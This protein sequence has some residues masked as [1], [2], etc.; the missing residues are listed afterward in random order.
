MCYYDRF[1]H[2]FLL[3]VASIAFF[4]QYLCHSLKCVSDRILLPVMQS[5]SNK[6][7]DHQL[8]ACGSIVRCVH[9]EI[10]GIVT[11]LFNYRCS[12]E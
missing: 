12:S 5:G 8:K 2:Y 3:F 1:H 10:M 6:L 4:C 9:F 7:E 11:F